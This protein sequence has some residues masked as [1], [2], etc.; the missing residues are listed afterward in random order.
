VAGNW[1]TSSHC[2]N[3]ECVQVGQDGGNVIVR[4]SQDPGGPVLA[5][6]GET[7]TAFLARL[8]SA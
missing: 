8:R 3:Y 6:S 1:R 5:F 2:Q 7:W 4:R